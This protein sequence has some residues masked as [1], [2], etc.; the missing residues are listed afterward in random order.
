MTALKIDC[1]SQSRH[2]FCG[3]EER[4]KLLIDYKF[5]HIVDYSSWQYIFEGN[6][7]H[8]V[9]YKSGLNYGQFFFVFSPFPSC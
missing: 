8:I 4:Q 1:G 6:N 3:H 9:G 2:I 7:K 5:C